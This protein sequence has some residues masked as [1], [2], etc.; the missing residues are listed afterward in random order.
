MAKGRPIR[1]PW[2]Q[3]WRRIRFQLLPILVFGGA[4]VLTFSLW[5]Q[6][7]GL[8][9]AVGAVEDIRYEMAAPMPGLLVPLAGPPLRPFDP[10]EAN[11]VIARLDD[12]PLRAAIAVQRQQIARL[13]ARLAEERARFTEAASAQSRDR[14][15][16]E[17][18][19]LSE[20]RRLAADIEA[21]RL[22]ILDRRS[23][24][25]SDT[26]ELE[27][28]SERFNE[29]EN[30]ADRGVE[31]RWA[32]WNARL[33]RDVV[34]ERITANRAALAQ[35]EKQL[36]KALARQKDHNESLQGIPEAPL[37]SVDSILAPLTADI[38]VQEA[39][40]AE[41][42]LQARNTVIRAPVSGVVSEIF[43]RPG[44]AVTAGM[45][46]LALAA[47]LPQKHVITYLREHQGVRP[48]KGMTVQVRIRAFPVRTVPGQITEVG[49]R[50]ERVPR[51]HLSDPQGR[52]WGLPVRI[53]IPS[54]ANVCPGELVDVTFTTPGG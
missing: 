25:A 36:A 33:R 11:Q 3:K 51:H 8:P 9:N 7:A 5:K 44:E 47:R 29:I 22:S 45:P 52:E 49:P 34:K 53:A 16:F 48:Q 15:T 13:Q 43:R 19:A 50:V 54:D 38:R 28:Q 24:I 14:A 39:Q 30:L 4:T 12:A 18:S 23:E 37:A 41:L 35:A 27:R 10:V 31:T 20:A 26:V 46:I 21:L 40:I 6:H 1:T 42:E 2:R 32:Y 17:Y